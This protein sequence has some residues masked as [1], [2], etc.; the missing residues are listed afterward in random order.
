M[1]FTMDE[2]K[3]YTPEEGIESSSIPS[4][5]AWR[6]DRPVLTSRDSEQG[7]LV[8]FAAQELHTKVYLEKQ[9]IEQEDLDDTGIFTDEYSDRATYIL[10]QN[11][12]RQSTCRYISANKKEGIRSLPTARHFSLD[13]TEIQRA[14]GGRLADMKSS[15]VIEVSALA[16]VRLDGAVKEDS[17]LRKLNTTWLLY[18]EILRESLDNGHRLWLLN[19]HDELVRSLEG[20]LGKEQIY[21]LGEPK[22]HMGSVTVPVAL[23]PQEVILSALEDDSPTGELKRRHLKETLAGVSDKKLTNK[24]KHALRE[25]NIPY[26][27]RPRGERIVKSPKVIANTALTGYALA[28]AAPLA[29]IEEFDGNV[30]VFLAI[31]VA[32]VFPY[33]WGLIETTTGKTWSRRATGVTVASGSFAAPYVYFWTQGESYPGYVNAA[34]G[35]IIAAAGLREAWKI[36]KNRRIAHDLESEKED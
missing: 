29:G 27:E 36:R 22:M 33:T 9:Y 6:I 14:I 1:I 3:R 23:N 18:S 17:E 24:M 12:Q 31:D 26:D 19:T 10:A 32:T 28:R 7:E 25:H 21:R 16:S 8:R 30:G 2:L 11:G 4:T 35:T 15:E 5:L 13:A 34:V 20:V